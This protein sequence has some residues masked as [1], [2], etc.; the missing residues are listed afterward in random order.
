MRAHLYCQVGSLGSDYTERR[1]AGD[2][3]QADSPYSALAQKGRAGSGEDYGRVLTWILPLL[4]FLSP[5][6]VVGL[7]WEG[8]T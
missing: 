1:R 6:R 7:V 3:V 5:L 2:G 4:S 8:D